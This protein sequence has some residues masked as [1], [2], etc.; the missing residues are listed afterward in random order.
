MGAPLVAGLLLRLWFIRHLAHIAGDGL[1][2]AD[3]ARNILRHRIYG[4]TETG[5]V[6]GTTMIRSTLIRLPGYP[7]FLAACFR[8]FGIENYRA[9]LC[10]QVAADLGTCLLASALAGRLFGQRAALA[11]LWLAALCPFT[12]N[13]SAA[14]LTETLVLSCI[15]L[16]FYGFARW[17]DAGMGFNRWLWAVVA[18]LAYGILLR[19]EQ[20][21]MAAAVM[22]AMLW[23]A[24][25]GGRG[26]GS[27]D[28]LVRAA[29]P[30]A[31]AAMC[32]LLPLVPWAARNWHTFHVFQPLAPRSASDPGEIEWV[33]F[34]RWY[35]TWGIEFASTD[36]VYWNYDGSRIEVGALPARAFAKGCMAHGDARS[37]A[38]YAPTAALLNDYNQETSGNPRFDARFAALAQERIKANL[39]CYYIALPAARVLNMMLRPRT[40]MMPIATQWWQSTQSAGKRAFAAGYAALNFAYFALAICG[41]VAWRQSRWAGYQELAW[42]MAASL[43]LRCALL[44]TLDNSEPRYTLEFFP[45]LFTWAG[46]LF[47]RTKVPSA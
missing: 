3:I 2:Y 38:L 25:R 46:G 19:P 28:G 34:E 1:V 18:G 23:G 45:V 4:F 37:A 29:W 26:A 10:V 7:L 33:G 6:P 8:L 35:R 31:A 32:V 47:A 16:V 40:E 22:P 12:A 30:V 9:V 20:G 41:L 42:A 21:L 39:F 44:L 14:A 36:A 13:Y 17:Q 11:V 15:A 24:V 43:L 27:R 5:P